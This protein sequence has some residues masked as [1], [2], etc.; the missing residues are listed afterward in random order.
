MEE[1]PIICVVK[2]YPLHTYPDLR[3]VHAKVQDFGETEHLC[4]VYGCETE[5]GVLYV[6]TTSRTSTLSQHIL[7]FQTCPIAAQAFC[8]LMT[9]ATLQLHTAGELSRS[10]SFG[11]LHLFL[12]VL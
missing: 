2:A 5:G 10:N 12:A 3:L 7:E 1:K 4:P 8:S 11:I 6:A 9:K